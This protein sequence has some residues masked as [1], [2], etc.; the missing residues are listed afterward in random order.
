MDDSGNPLLWILILL[1]AICLGLTALATAYLEQ[2]N[3]EKEA[4]G[5]IKNIE[6]KRQALQFNVLFL[7]GGLSLMLL[8]VLDWLDRSLGINML[9][10]LILSAILF[11]VYVYL[12]KMPLNHKIKLNWFVMLIHIIFYPAT[13]FLA[14]ISQKPQTDSE[15][16]LATSWQNIV[17]MIEAGKKSGELDENEY[18]M[19]DG[20][21]S[22]HDKMAREI[23]VPRTDAFMIDITNDNDRN[24]DS[25]L[26]MDYSRVPIYHEDKD[27]I[28]GI[29][30]IKTLVKQARN[31][32]FEHITIRQLLR[33]AFFVPET[34]TIDELLYQMQKTRNQM[35]IL[36]DEYG[37]VVGLV[38]LEDLLEEIV[39]EI[40]DE[41]DQPDQLY[42]A[43]DSDTFLI[44]GKMPLDDFNDEFGTNLDVNDVDTLAGFLI[45]QLGRIP[46]DNEQAKVEV[47]LAK[48]SL[49]LESREVE[50]GRIMT[51]KAVLPDALASY[52]Q[53]KE[54][55]KKQ[56][57]LKLG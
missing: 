44:R 46:V 48:G 10:V 25:M 3:T 37:G 56:N 16:S 55:I 27:N 51:I 9:F 40:D 13:W 6:Q 34:T 8:A 53:K 47:S 2:E 52:H 57:E 4:E 33:P 41:S 19:I 1:V 24:I 45:Y 11:I 43:V 23:M 39:G 28:V 35:A 50:E 30:H 7:N 54:A 32:G 5:S 15:D 26:S 17:E 31:F 22:M 42:K 49:I 18:E 21:I 29:V 36:L 38:T 20:V 14:K 12:A